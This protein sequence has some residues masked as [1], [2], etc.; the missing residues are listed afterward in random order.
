[1]INA[2]L[3]GLSQCIVN[4]N[5][6]IRRLIVRMKISGDMQWR[7][8]ELVHF[9]IGNTVYIGTVVGIIYDKDKDESEYT[10]ELERDWCE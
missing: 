7:A 6:E 5:P 2:A 10:I 9:T 1:M 3:L 4:K 8:S